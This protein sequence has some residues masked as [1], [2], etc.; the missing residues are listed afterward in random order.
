MSFF[1]SSLQIDVPS[2]VH[3]GNALVGGL[4]IFTALL[5]WKCISN[6]DALLSPALPFLCGNE[7]AT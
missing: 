4:C 5:L 1:F 2:H 7:Q 3:M 6:V